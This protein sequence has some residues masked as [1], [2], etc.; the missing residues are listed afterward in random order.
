MRHLFWIITAIV[1]NTVAAATMVSPQKQSIAGTW[2]GSISVAGQVLPMA[3]HFTLGDTAV[4]AAID[5]QGVTGLPLHN[6]SYDDASVHF[7]LQGGAGM[8][9][10]DGQHLGDS[11]GGTFTQA[12]IAGT[13]ALT[14]ATSPHTLQVMSSPQHIGDFTLP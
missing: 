1:V 14:R 2:S 8:A 12:G 11:I 5:I 9:V 13:F 3:V 4:S 10:F 7:E 6:I